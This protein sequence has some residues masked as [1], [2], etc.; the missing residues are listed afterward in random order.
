MNT[1]KTLKIS[2]PQSS[3]ILQPITR[4]YVLPKGLQAYF[5][6]SFP[7]E[8]IVYSLNNRLNNYAEFQELKKKRQRQGNGDQRNTFY[9]EDE[10]EDPQRFIKR[11]FRQ[12]T[13]RLE[14]SMLVSEPKESP[15]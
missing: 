7:K 11:V 10:E 9:F 6:N 4:N 5:E 13:P 2:K 1:K 15:R 14:S 12:H 3:S 8:F